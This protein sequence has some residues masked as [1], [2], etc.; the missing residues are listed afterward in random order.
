MPNANTILT[1]NLMNIKTY[2]QNSLTNM[3]TVFISLAK[4]NVPLPSFWTRL[5]EICIEKYIKIIL[6]NSYA[7]VLRIPN[8]L[9][10]ILYNSTLNR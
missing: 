1:L 4:N 7:A 8:Y 10:C 3:I 2:C 6:I 9:W 5:N